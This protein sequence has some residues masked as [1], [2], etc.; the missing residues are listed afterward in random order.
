MNL[1]RVLTDVDFFVL[2]NLEKQKIENKYVTKEE[3]IIFVLGNVGG[4][5]VI[6]L[7]SNE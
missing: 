4:G 1:Q 6:C 2:F 3:G 7:H 5:V